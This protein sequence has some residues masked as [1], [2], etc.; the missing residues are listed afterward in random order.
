KGELGHWWPQLLPDGE[1]V[2]FTNYLTP[3]ERSTV[4]VLS[5]RDR[6]HTVVLQGGYFGRYVDGHLVFARNGGLMSVGFDPGRMKVSG[7]PVP[8]PL[9]IELIASNGWGSFALSRNGTLLYRTDV[10]KS[11]ELFWSDDNGTETPALDSAGRITDMAVSPDGR[12]IAI[13]R[14]GDVWVFDRQRKLYS[15]LTRTEQ[16]EI[17]L[18]WTPDGREIVYARDVPQYDV[19]KRRADGGGPEEVVVTSPKDKSPSGFTPDGKFLIYNDDLGEGS[20]VFIMPMS[21]AERK[22]RQLLVGG[23]GTQGNARVSPDG[24]WL[25]YS[26]SESGRN[27]LY[28]APYPTD[29]GPARQQLSEEGSQYAQWSPDGRAIYYDSRGTITRARFDSNTGDIGPPE[30]LTKIRPQIGW[31]I[32]PDGRLLVA[33]LSKGAHRSYKVILDWPAELDNGVHQPR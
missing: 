25:V 32:A 3:A 10:Q 28:V 27:E 33:H 20:D 7:S 6:K 5:L 11:I 21:A 4:E 19:F 30:S 18:G 1:H 22:P 24:R 23:P 16:R 13:V 8:V 12:K 29:R 9:D 17:D 2:L 26:S 15:R 14:D 31:S